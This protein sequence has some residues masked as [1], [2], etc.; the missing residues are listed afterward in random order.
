[1]AE[2]PERF[3]RW[4]RPGGRLFA[5]RGRAPAMEAVLVRGG[6][7]AVNA[8]RIESLFETEIPYLAGAAPA[9]RFDW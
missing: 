5:V 4:L 2:V 3:L 9:P 7:G 6:G 1:V 8:P